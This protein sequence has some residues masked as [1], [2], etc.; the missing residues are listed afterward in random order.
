MPKKSFNEKLNNSGDLPR[1]EFIGFDNESA[2]YQLPEGV[3][4]PW[5]K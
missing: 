1:V 2:L 4:S 5:E 3:E